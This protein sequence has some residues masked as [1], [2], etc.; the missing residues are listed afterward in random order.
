MF[1]GDGLNLLGCSVDKT[2]RN[3]LTSLVLVDQRELDYEIQDGTLLRDERRLVLT[4][5]NSSHQH[6][7]LH[8]DHVKYPLSAGSTRTEGGLGRKTIKTP[9]AKGAQQSRPIDGTVEFEKNVKEIKNRPSQRYK[10]HRDHEVH[11]LPDYQHKPVEKDE[12]NER[13]NSTVSIGS[14]F[15]LGKFVSDSHEVRPELALLRLK[16]QVEVFK[17]LYKGV[18]LSS[19]YLQEEGEN[20]NSPVISRPGSELGKGTRPQSAKPRKE[21]VGNSTKSSRPS[22]AN[23]AKITPRPAK[24]I[25][26]ETPPNCEVCTKVTPPSMYTIDDANQHLLDNT[27]L[28]WDYC[29]TNYGSSA[30][31]SGVLTRAT[32]TTTWVPTTMPETKQY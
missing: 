3:I 30:V 27:D 13:P 9:S 2:L 31:A 1:A 32:D 22:S 21:F 11:K 6:R 17:L 23:S 14:S 12:S 26:I 19:L 10:Q 15:L 24:L 25:K 20:S 18:T 8:H 5:Y 4:A 7:H 29:Y 16:T 28:Q